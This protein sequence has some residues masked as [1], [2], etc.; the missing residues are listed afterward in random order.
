M[1]KKAESSLYEI[2][3]FSYLSLLLVALPNIVQAAPSSGDLVKP[4]VPPYTIWSGSKALCLPTERIYTSWYTDFSTVRT[5]SDQ[6]LASYP[7]GGNVTYRPGTRLVKVTTDPKV[8]AIGRNGILR[9]VQTEDIARQLFGTLWAQQ[10]DDLPDAFFTNYHIDA[11]VTSSADYLPAQEQDRSPTINADKGL[12]A[13]PI[14]PSSTTTT[15]STSPTTSS[16]AAVTAYTGTVVMTTSTPRA[17]DIVGVQVQ[18]TPSAGLDHVRIL[19]DG[20]TQKTCGY[21]PCATE[22]TIQVL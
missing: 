19:F 9:W 22:I 16:P 20:L 5:V 11:A 7:L 1:A 18:A 14:P 3:L 4:Q 21:N 13:L 2:F 17:G 6:E 8:Y 12:T 15:S 10:V